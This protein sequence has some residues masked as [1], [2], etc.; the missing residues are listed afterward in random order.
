IP[1]VAHPHFPVRPG[2][3]NSSSPKP[4]PLPT[5]RR[6]P[7]HQSTP[8]V[9]LYHTQHATPKSAQFRADSSADESHHRTVHRSHLPTPARARPVES[10][11]QSENADHAENAHPS[12][13]NIDQ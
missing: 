6:S 12:A 7:A 4:R 9:T 10:N 5:K 2:A 1:A 8:R 11:A 3:T 13:T